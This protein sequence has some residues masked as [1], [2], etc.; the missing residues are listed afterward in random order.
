MPYGSIGLGLT[1]QH[2]AAK[3]QAITQ[4]SLRQMAMQIA[5][6][7]Q[8]G[9]GGLARKA[10]HAP[11]SILGALTKV[12]SAPHDFI[13]KYFVSPATG[14][15]RTVT[16]G[17]Q[18][19]G[20]HNPLRGP[21][22]FLVDVGA[23]PL[24]Y[25]SFGATGG[26]SAAESALTRGVAEN[27]LR[28]AGEHALADAVKGGA[29]EAVAQAMTHP[30]VA[31]RLA[32]VFPEG[33][34]GLGSAVRRLTEAELENIPNK[35]RTGVKLHVPFTHLTTEPIISPART[36]AAADELA[37]AARKTPLV[38]TALK[39]LSKFDRFAATREAGLPGLA[40]R[41]AV[42]NAE[43][44]KRAGQLAGNELLQEAGRVFGTTG[45]GQ[46]KFAQV[47]FHPETLDAVKGEWSPAE[48]DLA[49]RF[50]EFIA[51]QHENLKA[52]NPNVGHIENYDV[53]VPSEELLRAKG[54]AEVEGA[55]YKT[56]SL[57]TA[58]RSRVAPALTREEFAR[59]LETKHGVHPFEE[60]PYKAFQRW[61]NSLQSQL[62][63]RQWAQAL[64]SQGHIKRFLEESPEGL[65]LDTLKK[66]AGFK[67]ADQAVRAAQVAIRGG[68]EDARLARLAPHD[69]GILDAF[70]LHA[71]QASKADAEL[72]VGKSLEAQHALH[73]RRLGSLAAAQ[74][75]FRAIGL[76]A[77]DA[78][79]RFEEAMKA[80]DTSYLPKRARAAISQVDAHV[81][82]LVREHEALAAGGTAKR[83]L[84]SLE[85]DIKASLDKRGALLR[86]AFD[87][88]RTKVERLEG[89]AS[90]AQS[91]VPALAGKV[92]Q[93][94]AAL[95][96]S[97]ERLGNL[98]EGLT[99]SG[100]EWPA[101]RLGLEFQKT[102]V[103]EG[104]AQV[105]QNVRLAGVVGE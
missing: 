65:S 61:N 7:D 20:E 47:L 45:E 81:D 6:A 46:S 51:K 57:A 22:G 43:V 24:S 14:H 86:D 23:D 52:V 2:N 66:V 53:R 95:N 8:G 13:M 60:N 5:Q 96:R 84:R 50:R 34:R 9:L 49:D 87:K 101:K 10:L 16:H 88:E 64:R 83:N 71:E 97:E 79:Q 100:R 76:E 59:E 12:I 75:K 104:W 19:F 32:Q 67:N 69:R 98:K 21:L 105:P 18:L 99:S 56:P 77:T 30:A 26:A 85:A 91:K 62:S 103:P 82:D 4:E 90:L 92:A 39:G 28:N 44:G 54:G 33:S 31:E 94:E 80:G 11:A 72:K 1:Q 42:R 27:A 48:Q 25:V 68:E 89:R 38:G 37:Q 58:E 41:M 17:S 3:Q 70:A 55:M 73:G 93:N 36:A 63:V 40:Y 15:G 102:G 29:K 74:E 35:F 78:R